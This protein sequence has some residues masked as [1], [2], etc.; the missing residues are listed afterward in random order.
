MAKQFF[1]SYA[2]KYSQLTTIVRYSTERRLESTKNINFN[3]ASKYFQLCRVEIQNARQ[4]L[5]VGRR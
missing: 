2:F 4:P 1:L 5:F 3:V